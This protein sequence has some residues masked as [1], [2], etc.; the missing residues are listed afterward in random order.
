MDLARAVACYWSWGCRIGAVGGLASVVTSVAVYYAAL[1]P[2]AIHRA[3]RMN[4]R[5]LSFV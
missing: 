5:W 2:E 4:R 1:S 3:L